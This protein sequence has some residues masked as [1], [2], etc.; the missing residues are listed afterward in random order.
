MKNK[1][2]SHSYESGFGLLQLGFYLVE[3]VLI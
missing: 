3:R 2:H 1:T